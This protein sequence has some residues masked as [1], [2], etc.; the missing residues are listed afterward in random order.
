MYY[1]EIDELIKTNNVELAKMLLIGTDSLD[2][3]VDYLYDKLDDSFNAENIKD[4][5]H[6]LYDISMMEDKAIEDKNTGLYANYQLYDEVREDNSKTL[7]IITRYSNNYFIIQNY[8]NGTIK[9]KIINIIID[10][11]KLTISDNN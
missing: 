10:D 2:D 1:N 4:R 11:L 9:H 8:S 3:Y 7:H 5:K 6:S